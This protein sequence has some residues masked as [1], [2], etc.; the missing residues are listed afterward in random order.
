MYILNALVSDWCLVS[1]DSQSSCV[2]IG[3]RKENL[4]L[5]RL[6]FIQF[7][8]VDQWFMGSGSSISIQDI[9]IT[10]GRQDG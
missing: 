8:V 6:Y 1:A 7:T 10:Q 5:E 9:L 2:R 3:I 4:V